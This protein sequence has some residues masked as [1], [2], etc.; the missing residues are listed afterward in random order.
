MHRRI[1]PGRQMIRFVAPVLLGAALSLAAVP[2]QADSLRYSSPPLP[3]LNP[4]AAPAQIA[5]VA[6]G[7]PDSALADKTF[8]LPALRP[9][10]AS[11]TA[12]T[13]SSAAAPVAA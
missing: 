3:L 7:A 10:N 12:S 1:R 8:V 13:S 9:A 5:S 4:S 11:K 2:S 6:V